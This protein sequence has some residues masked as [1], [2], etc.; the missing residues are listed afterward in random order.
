MGTK[1]LRR[2][3]GDSKAERSRTAI[4]PISVTNDRFGWVLPRAFGDPVYAGDWRGVLEL[5][6]ELRRKLASCSAAATVELKLTDSV[7]VG[8]RADA[9]GRTKRN[10]ESDA[11]RPSAPSP[12][13]R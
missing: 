12:R 7:S 9:S 5:R 8:R 3:I 1:L 13:C 11:R 4:K 10:P 2:L 6:S